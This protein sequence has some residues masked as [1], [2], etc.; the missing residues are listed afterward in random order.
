MNQQA[1]LEQNQ[2][3]TE[4]I[5]SR[6][7]LLAIPIMLEYLLVSAIEFFD[8]WLSGRFGIIATSAIG[9]AAYTTWLASLIFSLIGIGGTALVSR[10]WGARDPQLANKVA[11]QALI[12]AFLLGVSFAVIAYLMAESLCI[13]MG[14]TGEQKE[15]AARYLQFDAISYPFLSL[16]L[17]TSS[18]LRGVES[19]RI[20]MLIQAAVSLSNVFFSL[21]LVFGM[22]PI[23]AFAM[24]GIVYG[25]ILSR[26]LGALTMIAVLQSQWARL[27][28]SAKYLYLNPQ[29]S[30]KILKIGIPA[31]VEGVFIWCGHILFLRI[32]NQ[33][34]IT[35][36]AAHVVGVQV[37]G[38]SV[39]MAYSIGQA[40]ATLVGQSLGARNETLAS[41]ISYRACTIIVKIATVFMF[42][43]FLGAPLIYAIMHE[44][45]L[46][47][48][49]GIP[50]MRLLSVFQI[51]GSLLIVMV[52]ILRGA[53]ATRLTLII[54]FV[55]LFLFRLPFAWLGG[56]YFDGGLIGA[57]VGMGADLI[58]R[59]ILTGWVITNGNWLHTK[60]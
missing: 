36:F 32:V 51:P 48:Q 18:V 42:V 38:I 25:T 43:F 52:C 34:G 37:E 20:P 31:A 1:F 60:I 13:A 15:I 57:W 3:S 56:I 14:M 26:V 55:G 35:A 54:S 6:I 9:S 45:P 41:S 30:W 4:E 47:H 5:D 46:V 10:A 8:T 39:V 40:S 22:G 50:A 53:G 33:L 11:N 44:D 7:Y 19:V 24:D 16:T 49:Q 27:T 12:W 23:P 17:V 21:L 58:M 28:L 29:I 2:A 59:A